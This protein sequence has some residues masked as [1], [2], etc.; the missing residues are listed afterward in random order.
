MKSWPQA[1]RIARTSWA[2]A[3]TPSIPRRLSQLG[4][5][6]RPIAQGPFDAH[7][8]KGFLVVAG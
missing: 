6:D 5:L 7:P 3:T 8:L 2:E 1:S 4:E